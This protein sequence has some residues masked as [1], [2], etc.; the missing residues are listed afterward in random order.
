MA[1]GGAAPEQERL[2]SE[3]SVWEDVVGQER[4]VAQLTLA[5]GAPVHAYLFAGPPGCT[6]SEAASAF[7]ALVLA[8]RDDPTDRDARLALAGEHPDVRHVRRAGA[9]ISAEQVNEIIR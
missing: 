4:A 9:R 6:K 2:G 1:S 8:G 3:R 5:A 7:A